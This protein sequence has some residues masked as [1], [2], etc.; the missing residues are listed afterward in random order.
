MNQL[1]LNDEYTNVTL[2]SGDVHIRCH[3]VVL[4][5]ASDYFKAM[6]RCDLKETTSDTVQ[7]TMEPETMVTIIDYIYT[8]EIELTVDNAEGLVKACD[9]LQLDTL[10]TA[11]ENVVIKQVEPSNVVG[12]Y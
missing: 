9:I 3:C 6:F 1:R 5:V 10:K 7:L 12:F 4:A 2:V 8:G 11:C